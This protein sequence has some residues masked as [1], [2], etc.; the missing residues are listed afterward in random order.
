MFG[1]FMTKWMCFAVGLLVFSTADAA[2]YA[3][4]FS[5]RTTKMDWL[6]LGN[7]CLTTN[8]NGSNNTGT[9]T[10]IPVCSTGSTGLIPQQDPAGYGALR[11]T[12]N[13]G[14][15]TG[16]ILSRF[17]FP[18]N[19]GMQVTFTTYTYNG[20]KGGSA[21]DGA[22]GIAFMLTNGS[23]SMPT[24]SGGSGGSLGYSC[25]NETANTA[26]GMADAYLGL[27]IDEYGNFLNS[28]DNTD[29]GII[30]THYDTYA[31]S[32]PPPYTGGAT[33]PFGSN[34]WYTAS[35]YYQPM[36]IGLR[37]AGNTT[38]NWLA[39]QNSA[40]Y[41]STV[42]ATT[43]A[44]Y[45]RAACSTGKYLAHG[46]NYNN[47]N[48]SSNTLS[49]LP[50]N[51]KAINGG[52]YILPDDKLIASNTGNPR[53][54][55]DGSS[56][57]GVYPIT[58]KLSIS[59]AG[60]LNFAFSYNNGLYQQVLTNYQITTA[61]GPLPPSFRFGFSAGTGDSYNVHEITCF[62]ATP[63]TSNS[64]AGNNTMSGEVQIGSQIYLASY[65]SDG[66]WG[67]VRAVPVT[68]SATGIGLSTVPNWDANCVLTGGLCVSTGKGT[69][70][71]TPQPGGNTT[72]SARIL[73]TSL[74][75][76]GTGGGIS[77][78]NNFLDSAETTALTVG[79]TAA[80]TTLAWLRGNRSKEQLWSPPGTL[81]ARL[82][83]LGDIINS[84]STWVG[85]P[86]A[87]TYPDVFKDS[88]NSSA[89]APENQPYSAYVTANAARQ[90]VVYVGSND[91]FVHG[92]RTGALNAVANS[93][94]NDGQEV[95][96]FMPSGQLLKY[97][98]AIT[99]PLY[100]HNYVVDA[101][102]TAGDLFYNNSWHTWLVG[103]VGS[104][105]QEI[106]AL[107]VTKPANFSESNAAS[108]VMGDWTAANTSTLT[109]PL[110][111]LNCTVGTPAIVRLH[112]GQWAIIFGNGLPDASSTNCNQRAGT[113]TAGIYIGLIN[114]ANGTISS[115]TFLNTNIGTSTSRN[116]I[117]YISPV[118]V[119]GDHI[120]DYVY[121][122][123]VLGNVW[124]FDLTS[125]TPA[126]WSVSNGKPLFTTPNGQPITTVPIVT[127]VMTSTSKT[128]LP[129]IMVFFGTGQLKL[130]TTTSSSTYA[131][132]TQAFYGIWD[133]DWSQTPWK[134][135]FVNLT[136]PRATLTLAGLQQQSVVNQTAG[137]RTLSNT[138]QV[139]WADQANCG[140]YGW[141]INFPDT[142]EQTIYSPI[143]IGGA[144]VVNT[145]EPPIVNAQ[146]CN[147]GQQTGWTMAFNPGTGG[148]FQQSFFENASGSFEPDSSG[149]SVSGVKQNAV[150]TPTV[151]TYEGKTYEVSQ[152]VS[153][154]PVI[155]IVNPQSPAIPPSDS[156]RVSWRE[157]KQ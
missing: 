2:T 37:G 98:A 112:N 66:W 49:A 50:Y 36:R 22:D 74:S 83:V 89:S 140:S 90:A 102:P 12:T 106:Y 141:Y 20:D 114:P 94:N 108:L 23:A 120:T 144:I 92:F 56:N 54:N 157:I 145:V 3:E 139:C 91:G 35:G 58:Y 25:S 126:S 61:S 4:N 45:V 59:S 27:G 132:G 96:G 101:T 146:T 62:Q 5:G 109:A 78:Q 152:T 136:G 82:G 8:G 70:A 47:S 128:A 155:D 32:L 33:Y 10:S 131:T 41:N 60:L 97:A 119:D 13:K 48:N 84:G 40:Y 110:D 130:A 68:T 86:P 52:Y 153:N 28:D 55:S 24:T 21:K 7:A 99:N 81:R 67:T 123:D 39:Q 80:T 1:E 135:K 134:T 30:N 72:G 71:T 53:V 43:R 85:P 111:R 115:F 14:Q 150:G 57:A 42:S 69:S 17:T 137:Y 65:S 16:G 64:S 116:G 34:T 77:F 122:G 6:P 118:D 143:V 138:Q 18:T 117:A 147:P 129:R 15:Q 100:S 142:N 113:F 125:A 93:P 44:Q 46:T 76:M 75:T 107:D 73:L 88:I 29:S 105:G 124:R 121:A 154:D 133:W 104:A 38:W 148:G 31:N 26:D 127:N 9:Y 79:S 63:Q 151:V 103:G 95:I 156:A 11:L 87:D 19:E 149:T 51:Y